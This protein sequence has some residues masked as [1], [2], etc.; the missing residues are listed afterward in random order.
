MSACVCVD[1]FHVHACVY[2]CVCASMSGS[3]KCSFIHKY[4]VQGEMSDEL[5]RDISHRR[6]RLLLEVRPLKGS[7]CVCVPLRVERE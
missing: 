2:L 5:F 7:V 6:K 1:G 4:T 3:L